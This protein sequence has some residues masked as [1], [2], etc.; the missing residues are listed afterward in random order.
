[1]ETGQFI[2]MFF[3]IYLFGRKL[4]KIHDEIAQVGVDLERKFPDIDAGND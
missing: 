1:M 2:A 4:E 3:V